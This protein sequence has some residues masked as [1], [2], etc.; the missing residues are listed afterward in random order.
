MISPKSIKS[1]S[2]EK[3]PP[4]GLQ[5][6]L[7]VWA[8]LISISEE[9]IF[10]YNPCILKEAHEKKSPFPFAVAKLNP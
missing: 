5:T 10:A 3:K 1:S 4:T 2:G 7:M 8:I 9:M 6:S